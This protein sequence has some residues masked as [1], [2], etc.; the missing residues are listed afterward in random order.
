MRWNWFTMT[1]ASWIPPSPENDDDNLLRLQTFAF[2]CR[3]K[4]SFSSHRQTACPNLPGLLR[5]SSQIASDGRLVLLRRIPCTMTVSVFVSTDLWRTNSTGLYSPCNPVIDCVCW[6]KSH[7]N[8]LPF[9]QQN[10]YWIPYQLY[11][12]WCVRCCRQDRK[13]THWRFCSFDGERNLITL[14]YFTGHCAYWACQA[15]D[16]DPGC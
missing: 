10:V 12:R 3:N 14:L 9:D 15:L 2:L 7:C 6:G 4:R 13:S 1:V 8:W 11:G 5:R 16:P